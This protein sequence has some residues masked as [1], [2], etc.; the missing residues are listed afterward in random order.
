MANIDGDNGAN[1][2]IGTDQNDVINGFG[3]DDTITI[4]LGADSVYGGAGRDIITF[5]AVSYSSIDGPRGLIDG[6]DGYDI[7]DASNLSPSFLSKSNLDGGSLEITIGSQKFAFA[8]IE[9]VR[10]GGTYGFYDIDSSFAGILIVTS[11][12]D[13]TVYAK[14][15]VNIQL[16][17]GNDSAFISGTFDGGSNGTLNGGA[18][19][20]TLRTNIGFTVDLQ[21][22]T[23]T[24]FDA[25][26]AIS[27]FENVE[28]ILSGY[29][30][31]IYGD[32]GANYLFVSTQSDDGRIGILIDG[33]DGNDTISGGTG[34][35]TLSGS[36]G[37]DVIY[38]G[39]G[40]DTLSGG[41]GN[42]HLYGKSALGG[43]DGAD[44]ISGGDGSD[45][46][47][48]N[49]G[50]DTL[51][52]GEGSD[53]I[54]GGADN[55]S[56]RGGNGHDTVN[57]N[58]G[59]DT[60][61]GGA[62]NDSL[63]GG[64]G[65]D[66]IVGGTGNDVLSGDL[67]VDTLTG[68]SGSDIF[69]FGGNASLFSGASADMVIDF[70]DGSDKLTVGYDVAAVLMGTNRTTFSDAATLAQSLF[71]SHAGNRE[72]AVIGVGSDSYVFYSSNGG[73]TAD[74][75]VILKD[76]LSSQMT[77]NDFNGS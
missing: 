75:A 38:G 18:G 51:D 17:G 67:G 8:N 63:R 42:D 36:A 9:E 10:L 15:N 35:D 64:Q 6:G 60:I 27:G 72:V 50:N 73:D 22:G 62:G 44:S 43:P 57:G 61:D 53:R 12:Q 68:G 48:G 2:L 26:Y 5:D 21:A 16:A 59:N 37:H 7:I 29:E 41:T 52:G 39:S 56:I 40:A 4:G 31:K 47:Q 14:G 65:N 3:G 20:D 32:A 54:N 33:R 58:L 77:I 66:S 13:D 30:T 34:S 70:E 11:N 74:S 45:Y 76:V 55:D 28:S 19:I 49:A 71:D 69:V 46:I 24:A 25:S 23:A 1:T